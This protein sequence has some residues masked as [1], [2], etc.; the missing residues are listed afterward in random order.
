VVDVR[1]R[2]GVV[3]A[4]AHDE[5][6]RVRAVNDGLVPP[7]VEPHDERLVVVARAPHPAPLGVRTEPRVALARVDRV[8]LGGGAGR[9]R[10]VDAPDDDGQPRLAA[11]GVDLQARGRGR[12]QHDQIEREAPLARPRR[13]LEPC[14]RARRARARARAH[15]H[16][17]R[18]R[19]ERGDE[20]GDPGSAASA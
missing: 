4:E 6:R 2:D 1:S 19:G 20:E 17:A 12:E 5:R 3:H 18:A 9:L 14:L 10:V 11:P 7:V 8:R 15:P 13:R 16:P